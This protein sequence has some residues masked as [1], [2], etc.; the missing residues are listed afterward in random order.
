MSCCGSHGPPYALDHRDAANVVPSPAV[1]DWPKR[2]IVY[3]HDQRAAIRRHAARQCFGKLIRKFLLHPRRCRVAGAYAQRRNINSNIANR[4][5][6]LG[7]RVLTRNRREQRKRS[8][9]MSRGATHQFKRGHDLQNSSSGWNMEET[10]TSPSATNTI[11]VSR[12]PTCSNTSAGDHT[13]NLCT[14]SPRNNAPRL[15]P[16]RAAAAQ[17]RRARSRRRGTQRRSVRPLGSWTPLS[18]RPHRRHREEARR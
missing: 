18:R 17:A 6:R 13:T 2:D 14:S 8:A 7:K 5:A 16:G 3:P 4:K 11:S 12:A 15:P 10:L 9:C 1:L